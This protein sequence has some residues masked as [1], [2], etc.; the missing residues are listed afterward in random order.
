MSA[1]EAPAASCAGCGSPLPATARFCPG[2]GRPV[3]P[4]TGTT[5]RAEL[6]PTETGPVPV[7]MAHAQ[8]RWFGVTPPSLLLVLALGAAA[9]AVVLFALG[10]WPIA[11]ILVGAT[12]LLFTGFLEVARRKPDTAVTRV[13][14]DALDGMRARAAS[15]FEA[16]AARGRAGREGARVRIELARLNAHRR[17]LLT[18]FGDA[19][20]RG[21]DAEP[22]RAQLVEL[23]AHAGRL[24]QEL[25]H[26]LAASQQRIRMARLAVQETQMVSIPEPYPPPDE[27]TPPAPA[28]VPEPSP[29]PD[30]G[31]PPQ[32]DP[33]PTPGPGT[34]ERAT[35]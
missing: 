1:Y 5:V 8:P 22:F 20:Y 13:S 34:E 23:D 18:A 12:I 30:E 9:A 19:V 21:V 11:L 28:P 7:S 17:E 4:D 24:E 27:G 14:A 16:I 15:T 35:R 31:T 32:P 29:P 33:V 10:R 2:C 25:Q 3:D 6:P 26:V